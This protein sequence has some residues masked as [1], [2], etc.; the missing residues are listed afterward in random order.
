MSWKSYWMVFDFCAACELL[1]ELP[2]DPAGQK[3]LETG[4]FEHGFEGPPI[5]TEN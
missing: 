2:R 5:T 4:T 3:I 1:E